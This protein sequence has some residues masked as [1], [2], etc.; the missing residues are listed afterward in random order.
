M[1]VVEKPTDKEL[2]HIYDLARG[3]EAIVEVKNPIAE[4][5]P[6]Q[7]ADGGYWATYERH[8]EPYAIIYFR[9][10]AS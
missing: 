9:E 5:A 4:V 7:G 3:G 6:T 2:E 8:G 10:A 1:I